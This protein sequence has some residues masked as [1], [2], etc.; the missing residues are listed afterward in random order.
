MRSLLAKFVIGAIKDSDQ[1]ARLELFR[2]RGHVL[3]PLGLAKHTH[4]AIALR[5]SAPEQSP[6]GKDNGPGRNAEHQQ[7]DQDRLGDQT[8][9][10]DQA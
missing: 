7:D 1:R 8:A 5:A 6:L 3:Q 9:G 4:E 10:L 2:H